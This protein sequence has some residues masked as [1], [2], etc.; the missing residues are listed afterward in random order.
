M[1]AS[2]VLAE[3]AVNTAVNQSFD[4][5]IP[6]ELVDRVQIGQLVQVPFGTAVQHGIVIA[7]PE[8]TEINYLKPIQSILDPQPVV[9]PTQIGLARWMS[10]RYLAPIGSCLWLMLP[11]GLT[12]GRDIRV[13]LIDDQATSKDEVEQ[14]LLDLLRRRGS[15]RGRNLELNKTMQGKNW[16]PAVDALAKSKV[17]DVERILVPPR[18]KPRVIQTALLAIHPNQIPNVMRHLG[19]ESKQADILEALAAMPVDEPYMH[20]VTEAADT[21]ETTV[22]KLGET[23][24]IKIEKLDKKLPATVA[25]TIPR[26]GVLPEVVKFRKSETELHILRVLARQSEP[27]DVQW[28][29]AQTGAKLADLKKLEEDGLILLGEKQTWRD[30]LADR[31]FVPDMPPVLTPE[32]ADAWKAIED[33][34]KKWGW[35]KAAKDRQPGLFLLHGVTGSGKT[36]IY[37]RAIE[38]TLQ[39]GRGAIY[40]VPEIALTAQ[41]IRRVAARFPGQT[42]IIHSKLSEGERYDTWRRARE[43][44]VQV[45]VGARSA[46]F[47]PLPDVGLVILDEEHDPSYKQGQSSL[48]PPYYHA[49]DVA[50]QMMRQNNGVLILGS[51][52]PDLETVYRAGKKELR[53]LI[54]P[55][56]IMGHRVRILEQSERTGVNA[57]YYPARAAD[58]MAIDLP[59]VEVVDMRSELKDGNTSIFSVSLQK[60]LAETLQR[61]EQAILFINRRG[62]ATYVFC[63]DC[64]YVAN[65][66]RCDTPLT[67]HREGESLRCHRCGFQSA[68]PKVCPECNSNRIR[69]FGAGTQQIEAAMHEEFPK[70]R[71]LRWDADTASNPET[72]EMFLQ[73]FIDRK[74]DVLIGTQ[75]IA[76]GLDLPMVTLVG[77]VSADMGLNLPDFRAGERT[78]QLLTQVAGRAGRGLLGGKVI[79]QTYEPSNYAIQL[80]AKHDFANF[81]DTE[82]ASRRELGYPPFRR[83]ARIIFRDESEARAR[84]EAESAASGLRARIAKLDMPATEIIG[85]APCFFSRVNRVYRWHIILRS[86]DPTE[87]LRG[88]EMPR[89]W[90]IDLDPVDVL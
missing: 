16:R 29:Y 22:K 47:T 81:Y 3:I 8:T 68:P 79:L 5:L 25:L 2:P 15:T 36:E 89:G 87:V 7:F 39:Q 11:S 51:A 26:E 34:I 17:V 45:V 75:M 82:L 83:L 32:Q 86:P 37:L 48:G 49:R 31:D 77:V 43:G 44:L 28:V 54:L 60:A 56:R 63:R 40:L 6:T 67:F 46:L 74:A 24:L 4:Y 71:T 84:A 13:T 85:P 62:E 35:S 30:S 38:L 33:H 70:A 9:T 65:C 1:N 42:A 69:Y 72:H 66:P 19:R 21:T 12:N 52:T 58:A 10:D 78:F 53:A 20:L 61:K 18:V 90:H 88:W 50:E 73:R 41:T 80:A 55:T 14:K 57:R 64:G 27:I 59:P 23:G 76:K